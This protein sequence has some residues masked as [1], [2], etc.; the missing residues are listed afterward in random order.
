MIPPLQSLVKYDTANQVSGVTEK[1]VAKKVVFLH[2][3]TSDTTFLLFTE[4][5]IG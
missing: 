1:R 3:D 4:V 2:L 5:V